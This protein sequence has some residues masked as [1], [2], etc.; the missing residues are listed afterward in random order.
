MLALVVLIGRVCTTFKWPARRSKDATHTRRHTQ[1]WR[2][3]HTAS[4]PLLTC[5]QSVTEFGVPRALVLPS[6]NYLDHLSNII[7]SDKGPAF[8]A[9][10][11]SVI[12]HLQSPAIVVNERIHESL[13]TALS[14]IRQS[15]SFI[16]NAQIVITSIPA[17]VLIQLMLFHGWLM[18]VTP[19]CS[20]CRHSLFA[21]A[22]RAD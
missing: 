10:L 16:M 21:R 3:T 1:T 11:T 2:H 17:R 4:L 8:L 6:R 7:M 12:R 20:H 22:P 15:T 5:V 9:D 14:R 19:L 13:Q 18:T